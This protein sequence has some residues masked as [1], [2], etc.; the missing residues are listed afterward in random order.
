[1]KHCYSNLK[2]Q[3]VFISSYFSFERQQALLHE[4][5]AKLAQR[6][7]ESAPTTDLDEGTPTFFSKRE[8]ANTENEKT[9]MLVSYAC[10]ERSRSLISTF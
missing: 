7:K 6:E 5:L 1:M 3:Q 8:R 4:Q 9:E 2:V 10:C